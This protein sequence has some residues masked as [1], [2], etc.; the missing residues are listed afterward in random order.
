[1][2]LNSFNI[3][4][5]ATEI[6]LKDEKIQIAQL[7][8]YGGPELQ[9]IYGTFTFA[10]GERDK[11]KVVVDKFN[12]HFVPRQNLTFRRYKF[13]TTKQTEEMT[14]E[15]FV[16]DLR[17]QAKGCQFGDLSDELIKL[18][19]ICG[20][21]NGEIRHRLLQED[22]ADLGK[23]IQLCSVIEDAKAQ[24]RR[25]TNTTEVSDSS[26][27]DRCLRKRSTSSQGPRRY[28]I[29]GRALRPKPKYN[30]TVGIII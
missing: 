8:H 20:T 1:V 19:L 15:Q 7:L 28:S 6:N 12:N 24:A 30:Q 4:L 17:K 22:D 2:L 11:L 10:E 9:K 21:R 5:V 18:T 16:T 23:A 13:F 14:T 3:Y 29:V 27:V 26:N 25:M